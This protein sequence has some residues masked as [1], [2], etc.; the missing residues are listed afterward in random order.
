MSLQLY[1]R[2]RVIRNAGRMLLLVAAAALI[3]GPLV[4]CARNQARKHWWQFWR[5]KA[6]ETSKVYNPDTVVLPPAPDVLDDGSGTS[7]PLADGSLPAPP[8]PGDMTEPD[9]LRMAPKGGVSQLQTV[10]FEFDSAELTPEAVRVLDNNAAFLEA[11]P[12]LT[13]QIAGHTDERGTVEYNLNLGDRRAKAVKEYLMTRGVAGDR[14]HTI[15]YGEERPADAGSGEESYS[16]NRRAQF[17]V[18]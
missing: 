18:Y 16:K 11:N 13:I 6:T 4:G 5:P 8:S 15:S 9:A 14:L 10:L 7:T 1:S 12:D 3:G 17:L 2:P